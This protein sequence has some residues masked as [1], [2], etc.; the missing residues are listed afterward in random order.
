MS[1]RGVSALAALLASAMAWSVPA[2]AAGYVAVPQLGVGVL[3]GDTCGPDWDG[4]AVGCSAVLPTAMIGVALDAEAASGP[5]V[6]AALDARFPIGVH[7][8]VRVGLGAAALP[9]DG[10]RYGVSL[11]LDLY[12]EMPTLGAV[13]RLPHGVDD[14]GWSS[15]TEVELRVSLT[16]P[17]GASSPAPRT[18]GRREFLDEGFAWV[19][20]S[21]A[22]FVL[23]LDGRLR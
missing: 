6:G 13:L 18:S 7:P 20:V 16:N 22:P 10:L 2:G 8:S 14:D 3:G 5:W 15:V 17:L 19:L 4:E 12:W 11:G 21:W 23:E 1:G 9:D